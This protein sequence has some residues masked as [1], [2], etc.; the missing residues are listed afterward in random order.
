MSKTPD[1]AYRQ[2]LGQLLRRVLH[3]HR[4]GGKKAASPPRTVVIPPGARDHTVRFDPAGRERFRQT[5]GLD[6]KFVI[7]YSGNHSPCLALGRTCGGRGFAKVVPRVRAH[8]LPCKSAWMIGLQQV[9]HLR[10]SG[11]LPM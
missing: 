8:W 11:L 5:H 10:D 7:M 9:G 2:S 6:G 4:F 1:A 3:R